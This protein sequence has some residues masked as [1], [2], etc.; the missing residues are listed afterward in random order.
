MTRRET[1][2]QWASMVEQTNKGLPRAAAAE[3]R[4]LWT[5]T[6]GLIAAWESL[7]SGDHRPTTI[8]DWLNGPMVQAVDRLRTAVAAQQR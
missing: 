8:E 5:A 6:A 7:P 4:S 1:A 2:E 3:L